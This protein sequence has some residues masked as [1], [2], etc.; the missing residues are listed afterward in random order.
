MCVEKFG[1]YPT[2]IPKDKVEER[3][4][5]DHRFSISNY[6][7]AKRERHQMCKSFSQPH[8]DT[9]LEHRGVWGL[10]QEGYNQG[11]YRRNL[12]GSSFAI[13]TKTVEGNAD[14]VDEMGK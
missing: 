3:K 12:F 11:F 9:K 2:P 5:Y 4:M 7:N 8:E 10:Q 13:G 1:L 6:D 14:N